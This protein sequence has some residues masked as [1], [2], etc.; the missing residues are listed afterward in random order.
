MRE[1][2]RSMAAA[3]KRDA[4]AKASGRAFSKLFTIKSDDYEYRLGVGNTLSFEKPFQ[5]QKIMR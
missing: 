3:A 5:Q 1:E 4:A 2:L